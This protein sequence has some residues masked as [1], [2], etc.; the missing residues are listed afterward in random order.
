[1]VLLNRPLELSGVAFLSAKMWAHACKL[2]R[3]EV[4]MLQ[5]FH[6]D[7][8]SATL[9]SSWGTQGQPDSLWWYLTYYTPLETHSVFVWNLTWLMQQR[10]IKVL[11][12]LTWGTVH[13]FSSFMWWQ[14]VSPA[15]VPRLLQPDGAFNIVPS[16]APAFPNYVMGRLLSP[17]CY[18]AAWSARTSFFK[19]HLHTLVLRKGRAGITNVLL[20]CI[21]FFFVSHK[22]R[23]SVACRKLTRKADK[24][25]SCTSTN[26]VSDWARSKTEIFHL[27]LLSL[28]HASNYPLFI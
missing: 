17:Q 1:M 20:I 5:A 10:A 9:P 26:W 22:Q 18:S 2:T 14:N 6:R 15:N 13:S 23:V 12:W 21:T 7:N 3:V 8:V 27:L 25:S 4:K 19:V 11:V 24:K 28:Y 16:P